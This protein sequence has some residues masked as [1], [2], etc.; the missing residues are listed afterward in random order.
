MDSLNYEQL[1]AYRNFAIEK[2][3]FRFNNIELLVTAL[4][5]RSYVNEH[6]C[7]D[8]HNERL[9][10]LGDAVLEVVVSDYIYRNFEQPEGVMTS[11]RSA[12]VRTESIGAAGEELGYGPLVRL[13]K[14]EHMGSVR[15]RM[16]IMADCFEA[17]IGAI[18]L[19]QGFRKAR[20]F[21]YIHILS[22]MPEIL[23]R[24][25]W[26]D[27]KSHFQ[28]L[29]QHFDGS[30]PMYRVMKEEGPDHNKT[31]M[32]GAYV[33]GE[34]LATGIGHSKQ[35]AQVACA[36]KAVAWYREEHKNELPEHTTPTPLDPDW[37]EKSYPG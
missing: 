3:G 24:D 9:E 21:I 30:V 31:F 32:V 2:L 17:V 13:S 14:G 6:R 8:E 23:E 37:L 28:E 34:L 22:H 16:V 4:T 36:E 35:D 20:E 33:N 1:E 19:D 26:R 12:L 29:S 18:Y 7:A 27:P 25:S 10:F 5:H 15:A 11:W